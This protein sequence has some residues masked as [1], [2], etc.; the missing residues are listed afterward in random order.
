MVTLE[1]IVDILCQAD[2]KDIRKVLTIYNAQNTLQLQLTLTSKASLSN[3]ISYVI[4]APRRSARNLTKNLVSTAPLTVSKGEQISGPGRGGKRIRLEKNATDA[5]SNIC[6]VT[7]QPIITTIQQHGAK[8]VRYD[9]R[10]TNSVCEL[11]KVTAE[12]IAKALG[13]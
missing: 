13:K 1:Q 5:S 9:V 10:A 12:P 3:P 4:D 6:K 7:A 8:R 2:Q 11:E